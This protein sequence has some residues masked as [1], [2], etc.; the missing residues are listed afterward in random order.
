MIEEAG[1]QMLTMINESLNLYKMEKGTF[2]FEP[3]PVAIPEL[4]HRIVQDLHQEI[5]GR[6][7]EVSIESAPVSVSGEYSLC[8]SLFSNL[9]RNA[10]DASETGDVVR[11]TSTEDD[12]HVSISIWNR[13][14]IP[15]EVQPIFG[16]KYATSGKRE[17][18]GLGVYSARLMIETQGGTL[19]WHSTA[20]EGTTITVTLPRA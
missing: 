12:A 4:L 7:V 8:Y 1:R 10:I 20:E 18:T 13:L 14:P 15:E 5:E 2:T 16:Q 9:L 19:T 11:V 6:Q 17:G 3:V